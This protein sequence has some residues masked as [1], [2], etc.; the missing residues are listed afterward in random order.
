MRITEVG[1]LGAGS[2]A[3]SGHSSREAL[4]CLMVW[5]PRASV[6]VWVRFRRVTDG[7]T[8][9]S[10]SPCKERTFEDKVCVPFLGKGSWPIK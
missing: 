9:S 8:C 4:G 1:A 5:A 2:A 6:R 7:A 10:T 3:C